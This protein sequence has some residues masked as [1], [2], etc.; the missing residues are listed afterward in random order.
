MTRGGAWRDEPAGR[1]WARLSV[2]FGGASVCTTLAALWMHVV[3][4]RLSYAGWYIA[5]QVL[6]P[7]LL[8]VV[9]A[10]RVATGFAAS[11]RRVEA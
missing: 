10:C 11:L 8:Y 1:R 3:L 4:F 6:G 2:A 9:V 7:G 5:L